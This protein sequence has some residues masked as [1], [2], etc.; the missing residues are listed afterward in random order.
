MGNGKDSAKGYSSASDKNT[1]NG[2][3]GI[4]SFRGVHRMAP[5]VK[6]KISRVH[7]QGCG[8]ISVRSVSF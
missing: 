8:D 4:S 1:L 2:P 7:Y 3:K 5:V 6:P